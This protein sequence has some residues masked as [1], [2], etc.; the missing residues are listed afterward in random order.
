[1]RRI[2][3]NSHNLKTL[4]YAKTKLR[5][6][7]LANGGRHLV[8]SISECALNVLKGNVKLSSCR[9]KKLAKFQR[10]LRSVVD[11]SLPLARKKKLILQRGGFLV[12]LLAAVVPT[13]GTLLYEHFKPSR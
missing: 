10:Q 3:S 1:M 11:K 6:A 5:K 4:A 7:I 8:N 13:L 9:K 12:P 2:R